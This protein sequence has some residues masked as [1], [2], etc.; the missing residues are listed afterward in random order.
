MGGARFWFVAI[1]AAVG[2][3]LS[4]QAQETDTLESDVDTQD[5]QIV[6]TDNPVIAVDEVNRTFTVE[7]DDGRLLTVNADADTR[8]HSGGDPLAFSDLRVGDMVTVRIRPE[9]PPPEPAAFEEEELP[10]TASPLA[11]LALAGGGLLGTG[12][13]LRG[14]RERR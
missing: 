4:A 2:F 14:A 13:A 12:L 6:A 5:W 10:S 1:A 7:T 11:L 9:P 8:L 3:A